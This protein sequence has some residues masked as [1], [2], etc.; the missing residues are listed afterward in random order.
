MSKNISNYPHPVL[1]NKDDISG[2]FSVAVDLS[3]DPNSEYYEIT[4]TPSIKNSTIKSMLD[5]GWASLFLKIDCNKTLYRNIFE[6]EDSKLKIPARK[7]R[8]HFS[9]EFFIASTIKNS[10]YKPSGMN[11]DFDNVT[12][13]LD[14]GDYIA[15]TEIQTYNADLEFIS[16]GMGSLIKFK[17][18]EKQSSV[19]IE[20]DYADEQIFI[21]LPY[22]TYDNFSS[23]LTNNSFYKF[24][25]YS[26]LLS[27]V[28]T[29]A[30]SIVTNKSDI[31]DQYSGFKWFLRL[32]DILKQFKIYNKLCE[33]KITAF[34]A[35][36]KV[37]SQ[38]TTK[39]LTELTKLEEDKWVQNYD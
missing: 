2:E 13:K 17:K 35:S 11:E 30:I 39:M 14:I 22:K 32:T 38:P 24:H 29:E 33:G 15:I 36:Q 7:L 16:S 28:L 4:I 18:N 10:N 6:I 23:L 37:L 34:D 21:L 20:T 27:P 9:L 25:I 5:D 31:G 8:D 26:G 1:G 12:F 19:H 3:L